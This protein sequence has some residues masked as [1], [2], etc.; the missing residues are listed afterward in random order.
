MSPRKDESTLTE[1]DVRGE[2]ERSARPSAHWI[3][4]F[5]VLGGGL[6]AMFALIAFLGAVSG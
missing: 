4:L 5:S 2:H 3:Y 6:I 1:E